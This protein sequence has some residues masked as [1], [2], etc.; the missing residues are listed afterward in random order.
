MYNN[1][2]VTK[3]E[4]ATVLRVQKYTKMTK[5]NA[6]GGKKK[7]TYMVENSTSYSVTY[8]AR[9]SMYLC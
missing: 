4:R 9:D 3:S 6:R 8:D 2:T 1:K 5:T 7:K